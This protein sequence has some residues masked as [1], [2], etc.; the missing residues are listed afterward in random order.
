M[1]FSQSFSFEALKQSVSAL[2]MQ[3]EEKLDDIIMQ[4]VVKISA[5]GGPV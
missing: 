1:P 3:L 5:A 4:E 2:K